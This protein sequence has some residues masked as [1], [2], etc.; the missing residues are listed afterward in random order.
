MTEMDTTENIYYRY[1]ECVLPRIDITSAHNVPVLYKLPRMDITVMRHYREFKKVSID[2]PGTA[3]LRTCWPDPTH[4]F[5][6]LGS[7]AGF[8]LNNFIDLSVLSVLRNVFSIVSFSVTVF[9]V[10]LFAYV[11]DTH[12][13]SAQSPCG[14]TRHISSLPPILSLTIG[15]L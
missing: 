5:P 14:L 9:W 15:R 1:R 4:P 11:A 2:W 6:I 7:V 12:F 3:F 8:E 13:H 10:F